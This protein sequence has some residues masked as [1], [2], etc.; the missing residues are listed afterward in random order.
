MNELSSETISTTNIKLLNLL[1]GIAHGQ[2]VIIYREWSVS[3]SKIAIETTHKKHR[4]PFIW[5]WQKQI[6]FL[7]LGN[8]C[9]SSSRS[10][11]MLKTLFVELLR[12]EFEEPVRSPC[13]KLFAF[14]LVFYSSQ[15]QKW[16]KEAPS[17]SLSSF[18]E[19]KRSTLHEISRK[20]IEYRRS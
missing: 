7:L 20:S 19:P 15:K 3:Q 4:T 1:A 8:R 10:V 11:F 9:F 6:P 12:V 5:I 2:T 17:N 16:Q 13:A 14:G 18:K